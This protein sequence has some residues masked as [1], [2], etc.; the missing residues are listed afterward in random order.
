M[1][2][3]KLVVDIDSL[4]N[5]VE[6]EELVKLASQKGLEVGNLSGLSVVFLKSENFVTVKHKIGLALL[7]SACFQK[8]MSLNGV[9]LVDFQ[10]AGINLITD[11]EKFYGF[12]G[13]KYSLDARG[14]NVY[15][16]DIVGVADKVRSGGVGGK[17]G[18]I[19]LNNFLKNNWN[20]DTVILTRTQNPMMLG[21]LKN[22]LPKEVSLYPF[23]SNPCSEW[24]DSV[25]ALVANGFIS[26]NN[27]KDSH[28]DAKDSSIHWG[29]YGM[30]GDGSTWEN[31]IS[32]YMDDIDWSK[33]I[34][35]QMIEYLLKNGTDLN[36]C[37]T[38]GH[39]LIVGAYV[40]SPK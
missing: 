12:W 2:R 4:G 40:C 38:R 24:I 26:R 8:A 28:F 6:I 23:E 21:A 7:A 31:M 34:P 25:N 35:R 13:E 19:C 1:E 33:T 27:R 10:N 15:Y 39:A 37:L 18:E 16:V 30:Y 36:D 14:R 22:C 29:A 9:S 32:N 17:L 11:G 20:R 3:S 5:L